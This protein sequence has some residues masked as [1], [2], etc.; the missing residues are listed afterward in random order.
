MVRS[1]HSLSLAK[2]LAKHYI[3]TKSSRIFLNNLFLNVL[4]KDAGMSLSLK[5][6]KAR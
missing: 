3:T 1:R 2:L 6:G 5:S 4:I